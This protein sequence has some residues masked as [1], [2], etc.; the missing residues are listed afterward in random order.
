MG[1]DYLWNIV[2][3]ANDKV[4]QIAIEMLLD[5][6]V[7][8][9]MSSTLGSNFINKCRDFLSSSFNKVGPILS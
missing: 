8:T 5:I 1:I 2:L 4:A 7:K 3:I 6:F 9:H